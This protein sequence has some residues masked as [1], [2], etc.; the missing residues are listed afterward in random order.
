MFSA[1]A[2]KW[3]FKL[4]ES[5]QYNDGNEGTYDGDRVEAR[6]AS[7]SDAG[8]EPDGG[9]CGQAVDTTSILDNSPSAQEADAGHYLSCYSRAGTLRG[10]AHAFGD[11]GENG[12]TKAY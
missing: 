2:L 12:G 10:D 9:G 3:S 7:H 4:S 6:A 11:D 5:H 1:V 8:Y